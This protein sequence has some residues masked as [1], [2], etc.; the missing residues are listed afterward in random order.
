MRFLIFVSVS[1]SS[2]LL[3]HLMDEVC[4]TSTLSLLLGLE[5]SITLHLQ[6][7]RREQKT[8]F[9]LG[10]LDFDDGLDGCREFLFGGECELSTNLWIQ[11]GSG[12]QDTALCLV[13][14]FVV[15]DVENHW[16]C[17]WTVAAAEKAI[18][19]L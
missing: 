1:V 11:A 16:Q 4:S 7:R 15:I 14:W 17:V 13:R 12:E 3:S 18:G 19:I 5:L 10:R 2:S 9:Y 8:F 6:A